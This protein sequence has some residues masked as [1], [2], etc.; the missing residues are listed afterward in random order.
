[1]A[2]ESF[3]EELARLLRES[4]YVTAFTG[5]G[6]STL[7]GIRDFRGKNGIYKS[8]D[9]DKMFDID[10]FQKDPSIYYRNSKELIYNLEAK[11]PSIVHT[12]L[13]R[14]EKK[15]IVRA[16][17]TQNI[18]LLHKKAGS[19]K[20]LE[21]HGTPDIHRCLRCGKTI[22][23]R[24]AASIVNSGMLPECS[25]CGGIVKPD[26]VFFGE[27]LPSDTFSMAVEEAGKSDL[28]LLL[29]STLVV[30]PAASI[31][32]YT[33][34]NRGKIV[35]VNNMDTPLDTMATLIYRDLEA[36]FRF[37]SKNI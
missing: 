5:A 34:R 14:L 17:I 23:F 33:L 26:I 2:K 11:T 24:E 31:P 4:S 30:Q 16:V 9:A 37:I 3:L 35:I 21:I 19:E 7:S 18:D 25:H 15:G 27:P 10:W 13:A 29:G 1:M 8:A 22:P 6:I 28:M 32:L 12:E 20:V 36:V